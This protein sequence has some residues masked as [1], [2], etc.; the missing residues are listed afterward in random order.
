MKH[1]KKGDRV[2][3]H[4]FGL[5]TGKPTNAGFQ[6]YSA[7]PAIATAKI[8]DNMSFNDATVLPL[9]IST[10]AAGLYQPGYLELPFPTSSPK[11][12]GKVI[13]VWGGSSS[14]GSTAIQ[15]AVAS[16]VDVI[17]TASKRNHDYAANLGAKGVFDYNSSSVVDDVVKAVKDSG[18]Q[19]AGIYD[20]I[21]L[22]E[23]FKHVFEIAQKLD[24]S[25]TIATVLPPPEKVPEGLEPKGVFAITVGTQHKDV[26]EAVWQKFVPGALEDGSLKPLPEPLIVGKGLESV[27][28]G[29]DKQREGVSAKKVIIELE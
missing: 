11:D 20:S 19:F 7:V 22:P 6:H 10:A 21:S 13:V 8:P 23:S 17:T 25:K 12:S 1:V 26:G 14:V 16:G 3:A 9:A 4:C 27:Q 29:L 2:L 5:G 18:K 15:L 28:K 24:G